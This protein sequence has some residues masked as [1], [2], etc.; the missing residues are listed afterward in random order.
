[1][2]I[3]VTTGV[4]GITV[5][6]LFWVFLIL[7]IVK[8]ILKRDNE[9]AIHLV[10]MASMTTYFVSSLFLFPQA[11]WYVQFFL[12]VGVISRSEIGYKPV[13]DLTEPVKRKRKG[14]P[15]GID[16]GNFMVSFVAIFLGAVF[17][18]FLI[19]YVIK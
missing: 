1:M 19:I 14:S 10:I 6:L 8:N 17:I 2:D 5:W 7:V 12:L 18:Y 4:F 15:S 9:L 13:V 3:L 11:T 16:L